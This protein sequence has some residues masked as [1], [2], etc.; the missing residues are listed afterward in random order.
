MD[1]YIFII[2]GEINSVQI[3][4]TRIKLLNGPRVEGGNIIARV[5]ASELLGAQYRN[6]KAVLNDYREE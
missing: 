5:D 1:K 4:N 3:K 2:N 6:A